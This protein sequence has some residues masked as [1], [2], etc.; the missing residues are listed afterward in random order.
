MNN[1]PLTSVV[2]GD[3]LVWSFTWADTGADSYR[4]II[5]G[6]LVAVV[7]SPTYIY[8]LPGYES[9]PPPI[10]VVEEG[11]LALS[12]IDRP[13][14]VLQWWPVDCGFYEVAEYI[15]TAWVRQAIVIENRNALYSIQTPFLTDETLYQFRVNAVSSVQGRSDPI[16]FKEFIV[17]PPQPPLNI[18]VGFDDAT[19]SITVSE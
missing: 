4:I 7:T 6:F 8:N 14:L 12:E 2:R 15:N 11:Q 1:L 17:T 3:G 10:E 5:R 18:V 19:T 9:S 13:F 16:D